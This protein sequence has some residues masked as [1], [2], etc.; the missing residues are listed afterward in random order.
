MYLTLDEALLP[1]GSDVAFY[2]QHGWY[3]SKRVLSEALLEQAFSGIQRHFSG[4]R[5]WDLPPTSGFSG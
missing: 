3:R 5:D 1:S 2:R 4:E